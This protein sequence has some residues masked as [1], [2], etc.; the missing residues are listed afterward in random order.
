MLT[1]HSAIC[2]L[3]RA[4]RLRNSNPVSIPLHIR[5]ARVGADVHL[6]FS[7]HIKTTCQRES[8]WW[9]IYDA[10]SDCCPFAPKPIHAL[11]SDANRVISVF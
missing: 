3:R 2:K 4:V 1:E 7:V 8:A 9:N 11:N 10:D 6:Q 5:I